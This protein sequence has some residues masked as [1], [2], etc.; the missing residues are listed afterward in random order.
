M[1]YTASGDRMF[2]PRDLNLIVG[3]KIIETPSQE[4]YRLYESNNMHK[5]F[6]NYFDDGCEWISSPKPR[7]I[8]D[9]LITKVDEGGHK[10]Q[11]LKEDEMIFEA[12][13]IV[14]MGKDLLYLVS[15]SGNKKGLEWLRRVLGTEYNVHETNIYKSSHIDSTVMCLKPGLV[16]LNALRVNEKNCPEIFDKWDKIYFHDIVEMSKE[17]SEFHEEVRKPIHKQ[18]K[19]MGIFTD[20]GHM[21]SSWIG[22]NFLS[23]APDTVIV[24]EYQTKLIKILESR[25]LKVIPIKWRYGYLFKG[26]I[27]C[28]TLDTV[29]Q[30]QLESYF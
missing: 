17:V 7:L 23:I 28:C 18:L 5:I 1:D 3:N 14:R 20:V 11:V 21:G 8:G 30:S 10:Y 16:V 4:K 26:G 2:N 27:H 6:Y 19:N 15:R 24:D 9:Y 12:A 22:M 25:K 13:N 29:R